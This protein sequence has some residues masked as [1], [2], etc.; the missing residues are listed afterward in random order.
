MALSSPTWAFSALGQ[1]HHPIKHSRTPESAAAPGSLPTS[2]P[3]RS[4]ARSSPRSPTYTPKPTFPP[5]PC[6]CA[7][8]TSSAAPPLTDLGV[9]GL[10]AQDRPVPASGPG[11]ALQRDGVGLSSP[12][13]RFCNTTDSGSVSSAP[14]PTRHPQ[15]HSADLRAQVRG[16]SRHPRAGQWLRFWPNPEVRLGS[17]S[18]DYN[19]QKPQRHGRR[20][21]GAPAPPGGERGDCREPCQVGVS[22]GGGD[23][24]C[25]RFCAAPRRG[26]GPARPGHGCDTWAVADLGKAGLG[27]AGRPGAAVKT[28]SP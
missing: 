27:P 17:A 15:G 2:G 25:P 9:H 13:R 12:L 11:T 10:A 7:H 21:G 16:D 20:L 28:E 24:L 4:A 18:R 14:S 23:C 6:A 22:A 5:T 26:A 1:E 3:R 19:S 8:G